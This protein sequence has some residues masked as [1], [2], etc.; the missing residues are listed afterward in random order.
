MDGELVNGHGVNKNGL[1]N[2]L[3]EGNSSSKMEKFRRPRKNSFFDFIGNILKNFFPL[4]PYIQGNTQI[5]ANRCRIMNE[6]QIF[7][8]SLLVKGLKKA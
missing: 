6:R 8:M 2:R 4:C 3:N 5:G 7:L 1:E